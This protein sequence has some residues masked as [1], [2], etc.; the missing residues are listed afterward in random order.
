LTVTAS[1]F[2]L[3]NI[4]IDQAVIR[5]IANMIAAA[6]VTRRMT[7]TSQVDEHRGRIHLKHFRVESSVSRLT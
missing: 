5:A 7:P 2:G 3:G 1:S 6:K 4:D